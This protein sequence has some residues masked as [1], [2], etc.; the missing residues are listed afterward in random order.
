MRTKGKD[1]P[2]LLCI[3]YLKKLFGT[4]YAIL[5]RGG[6]PSPTPTIG[7]QK[8]YFAPIAGNRVYLKN[9]YRD[10]SVGGDNPL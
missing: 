3:I 8:N 5:A 1:E 7:N 4:L 6:G 9:D 10:E 2:R